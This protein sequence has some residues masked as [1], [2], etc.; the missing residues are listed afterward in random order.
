MCSFFSSN[1]FVFFS[2]IIQYGLG[3]FNMAHTLLQV[4]GGFTENA[5]KLWAKALQKVS[6]TQLIHNLMGK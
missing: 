5:V 6:F 3:P 1:N 2:Q 4:A